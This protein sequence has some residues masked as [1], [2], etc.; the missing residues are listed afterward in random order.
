VSERRL[1]GVEESELVALTHRMS[2]AQ[3]PGVDITITEG[4]PTVGIVQSGG[5]T[6]GPR[7]RS[8][9]RPTCTDKRAIPSP[10]VRAMVGLRIR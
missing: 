4:G 5:G 8:S 9:T 10:S 2:V 1:T 3:R 7:L 6:R